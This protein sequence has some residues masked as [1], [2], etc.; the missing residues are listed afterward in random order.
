MSR[1]SVLRYKGLEVDAQTAGREL[2]VQAVL[3]G[4]AVQRGDNLSINTEL[5]DVR[6]NTH[7]WG[8]EYNRKL[9]D[10]LAVQE[11]ITRDISDKLRR[12]LS[13]EEEKRLVRHSTTNP[14]AYRLYLKGRYYAEKFT[15][16]GVNKGIEAFHQAIDLDPNYALAY[17][18]LSYAYTVAD[19]FFLSPREC[20][21][22]SREAAKK[23]LELDDTSPRSSRRNGEC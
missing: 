15:Q 19:D 14:E 23:A 12:K 11:E 6:D 3:T 22:R 10:I 1:N 21:P 17:D 9:A 13:K 18:G 16:E 7:L 4:R 2:K 8:E 20:M 5:V